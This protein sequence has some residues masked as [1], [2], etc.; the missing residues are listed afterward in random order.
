MCGYGQTLN[1]ELELYFGYY[2]SYIKLDNEAYNPNDNHIWVE[3]S[4]DKQLMIDKIKAKYDYDNFLN[5]LL[6]CIENGEEG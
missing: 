3:K 4:I 6:E 1:K 2:G 5:A